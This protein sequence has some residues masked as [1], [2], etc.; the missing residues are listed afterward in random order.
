MQ[1]TELMIVFGRFTTQYLEYVREGEFPPGKADCDDYC[2]K[3]HTKKS[4]NL[5]DLYERS[6]AYKEVMALLC[7][8]KDE[9]V[10]PV[11]KVLGL[12]K[13]SGLVKMPVV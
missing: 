5:A 8:M 9:W 1:Q 3:Y 4:Y 6:H 11:T 10:G 13:V 12:K 2:L 7:K